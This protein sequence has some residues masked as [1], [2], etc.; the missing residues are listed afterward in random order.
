MKRKTTL[1]IAAAP[2]GS[3]VAASSPTRLA[4]T[5]VGVTSTPLGRVVADGNG[6]T[7]Y[8]F[9]KDT[10]RRSA[11]YGQ[12]ANYWPSLVAR[13]KP[14][15]LGGARQALLGTIRRANGSRQVT[16]AGHPLYRYVQDRK[17]GQTT[18]EGSLLFGAGSDAL[19]P[20][21]K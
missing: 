16:Y 7:L 13:G 15:A 8:L 12:C 3:A 17:P 9:E 10:T 1:F 2:Y 5:T 18:G 4:A 19:S 6:R 20:A 11:C 14:A 21:G